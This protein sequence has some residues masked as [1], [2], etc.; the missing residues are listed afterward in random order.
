MIA[1]CLDM[2]EDGVL[3]NRSMFLYLYSSLFP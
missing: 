1:V 2:F 3:G